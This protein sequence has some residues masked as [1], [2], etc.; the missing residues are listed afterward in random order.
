[1]SLIE[2]LAD[3]VGFHP[4]YTGAFGDQVHAKDQAKRALLKAMGFELD[5]ES[6][7][8]SIALLNQS[9]WTNI[10]PV[11]HIAKLEEQQHAIKVSL[12]K[13]GKLVLNWKVTPEVGSEIGNEVVGSINV[14]DMPVI[15]ETTIAKT[16][17]CQYLLILPTVEQ[18]YYQ[19]TISFGE[20]QASCPLIYAPKTCYSP[21]TASVNKVWGYTAQ[22]YS[23]RSKSNWGMGDFTDLGKLVEKSAQQQAATIGLNPL[24][25][26]YQQNP[27]HRS[28][29]SP[30]SRCFL[31]PL[32]IDVSKIPNY[33]FCEL[34]QETVNNTAFQQNIA[35]AKASKLV[36]YPA[37]AKLKFEITELLFEDFY[38]NQSNANKTDCY[39]KMSA[40]FDHFKQINGHDLQRFATF[41][42]LYEHFNLADENVYGWPDWPKSFQDPDSEDVHKFKLSHAKRIEYF[43]FVQWVAHKQLS[44]VAQQTI[45]KDMAIG[46]YLDLAVG[47]DGSG[48]DVWSDKEVYVA[49]AS[50]GAPPD[51]MNPLGQNWGL[52][53]INPVALQKQGYQPL[54]K[55]LRSSMQ[56]AGALRID[57]ILGLMRQYWV[58]PGMEA[59]EG[60]YISFPWDDILRII[61][62]E[63]RRNNCVVIGEDLGN[64]PEGFSETIQ[65]SGLLSFKVLFFERWESG[66]F[67]RP[68]NFPTQSI[69]TIATHDTSTLAGWWQGRDL[70]W[71]QQLNLY[72]NDEAG[73]ADRNARASE[74]ENLIAALNDLQVIDMSKA[75]QLDPAVMNTELSIGVQKY[76]AASPSHIQLIPLEDALEIP[77]QVNI[78]GTIDQHPNWLQKLPV[79]LEDFSQ[80]PSVMAIA[81]AMNIARPK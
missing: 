38:L 47:C 25:P 15:A 74:R 14:D 39:K 45:D 34:A 35:N 58:A 49:G 68:D 43:C 16:Q 79:S 28:P 55:A 18:G 66:L 78:P 60:V 73:H 61:S 27:A 24:H 75:P 42:T 1:M 32:Y 50:I 10:L 80:T 22:L 31:N 52:T 30:S 59:D 7:T 46:L 2:Q 20:A 37:V 41:D 77:E 65:N 6:L 40:E 67:K 19:L 23:L 11:V 36:D 54:V 5:D 69:V 29:Y 81:Q 62:L 53:P 72:P 57:H 4:S 63:S 71:R 70:Q 44:E 3:I 13:I 26:L 33:D 51:G 64:V 21:Q 48:F 12:P 8:K 17:Y 56:Y 76:L 9:Q